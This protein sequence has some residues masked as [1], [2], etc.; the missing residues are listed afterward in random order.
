[1]FSSAGWVLSPDM[2]LAAGK[3]RRP[4]A[5][6]PEAEAVHLAPRVAER[7]VAVG[8]ALQVE[9]IQLLQV[10]AHDLQKQRS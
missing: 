1:M 7:G 10:C 5:G 9:V 8:R 2:I 6:L 3:V 4:V